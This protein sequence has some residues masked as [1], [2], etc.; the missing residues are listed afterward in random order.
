MHDLKHLPMKF[1]RNRI[2]SQIQEF[3]GVE[4]VSGVEIAQMIHFVANIYNFAGFSDK[5]ETEISGQRWEIMM[6]LLVD[7]KQGNL[8]GINPTHISKFRNVSKNTVSSLLRGLEEQ[9]LVMREL[10]PCDKRAFRIKLTDEGRRITEEITPK[11]LL[12]MNQ[13]ADGLTANEKEQLIQLLGKLT[14]SI[15]LKEKILPKFLRGN[16]EEEN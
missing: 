10:D 4:D 6:R 16:Y 3:T 13:L 9:G 15:I 14:R 2:R 12:H 11:R 1:I 5:Q 7:E 8:G